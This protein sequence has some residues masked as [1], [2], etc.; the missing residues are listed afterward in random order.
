MMGAS[1]EMSERRLFTGSYGESS[2]KSLPAEDNPRLEFWAPASLLF[3]VFTAHTGL[4]A[5]RAIWVS[6][7][8]G[9]HAA[10]RLIRQVGQRCCTMGSVLADKRLAGDQD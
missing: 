10:I 4:H 5:T 3:I 9:W 6:Q 2:K 7:Y 8:P 1:R